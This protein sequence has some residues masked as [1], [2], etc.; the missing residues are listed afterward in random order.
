MP[1][2]IA[3]ELAAQ[4]KELTFSELPSEVV[5]QAKRSLLDTLGV[6]FGGY[7]SEPSRI[8]QSLAK[9]MSG[10]TESTVFASGLKTSCLYAA[11]ANGVMVRYLDYTDRCFL[12][13]EA[14]KSSHTG[15]NGESIPPVLAVGERQH[16]SG[17]EIITA[18]VLAYEYLNK[19]C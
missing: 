16:S 10:S 9:E 2:T 14:R 17:Q 3:E 6:G 7:L 12:T 11:L 13:K 19:I 15:H 18:I 8:M 1:K 5:R 4:V